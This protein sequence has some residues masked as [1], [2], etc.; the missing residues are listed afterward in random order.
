MNEMMVPEHTGSGNIDVR[1]VGFAA[2]VATD[3]TG[4][5]APYA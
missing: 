4:D 5:W 3:L 2:V 1:A